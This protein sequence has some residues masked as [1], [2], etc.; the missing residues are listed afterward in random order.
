LAVPLAR[1]LVDA[2]RRLG[3]GSSGETRLDRSPPLHVGWVALLDPPESGPPPTFEQLRDH[4]ARRLR[5][6]ARYR[7]RLA[8]VPFGVARP[9]WVDD[10]R[11]ELDQHV[12][13]V[14]A[15]RLTEAVDAAMSAPHRPLWELWIAD[16]LEDSRLGAASRRRP[17]GL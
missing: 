13:R 14:S 16:R 2:L 3:P 6:A 1:G 4:I 11:F 12:R 15:T 5:R 8:G 10:D 7:Q 17:D 9:V